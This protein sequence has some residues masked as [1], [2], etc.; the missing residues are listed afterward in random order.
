MGA[1][2]VLVDG[3]DDPAGWAL[4]VQR[5]GIDGLVEVVPAA[6]TVLV[7]FASAEA[8]RSAR[9]RL[10]E[11]VP[12]TAEREAATVT[13]RVRYDGADLAAVA[14]AVGW[15]TDAVVAA[16]SAVEYRAAFCGFSPGFAYLTGLPPELR[17][18]R[19]ASPRTR[20]PAGAVAIASE[21]TAV[22]PR[23]TP[24]GWHLLGTADA[25]LFDP[26]RDPPALI[27][28]GTRVRFEPR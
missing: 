14:E 3:V 13:I 11:V 26:D 7:E 17:L 8:L 19:R 16:H 18:A 25:D 9:D 20:V 15:S 10:A 5:A 27:A 4:G 21:Y 12:V 24:G 23:P 28:P 1:R 22:Y 6:A 2:A